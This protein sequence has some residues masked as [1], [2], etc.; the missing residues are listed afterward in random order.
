M[1]D[2]DIA[3]AADLSKLDAVVHELGIEDSFEEPVDCIRA[4]KARAEATEARC[5]RLEKALREAIEWDGCDAY[6][7]PA[8]WLDD[9]K[10]ALSDTAPPLD[11][12]QG[13]DNG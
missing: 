10:A 3:I 13:A 12:D 9:A 8:V 4:L 11:S 5:A 2:P 6:S 7:E 1:S